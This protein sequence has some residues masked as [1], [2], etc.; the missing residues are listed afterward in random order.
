MKLSNYY[1]KHLMGQLGPKNKSEV[2]K[3]NRSNLLAPSIDYKE[4]LKFADACSTIEKD[5][6]YVVRTALKSLPAGHG[7]LG[8]L[9]QSCETLGA[10]C[11]VGYRFQ[12]LSRSGMH[13]QLDYHENKVSS[14]VSMDGHDP[15]EVGVLVEYFQGSLIAIASYLVESDEPIQ[16]LAI[17]FMHQPRAPIASYQRLFNC[18]NI[19]FSQP[20]NKI[21]FNRKIMDCPIERADLGAKHVLLQEAKTQLTS[22]LGRKLQSERIKALL[23]E[24]SPFNRLSIAECAEKLQLKESSLKR[25]LQNEGTNYKTIMNSVLENLAKQ[26]LANEEYS[27]QYISQQL[28]FSDRSAFARSFKRW[29]GESPLEYR[30]NYS[31]LQLL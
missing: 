24:Q 15:E 22:L 2:K 30:K 12:H 29:S 1:Y 9:V 27:I 11:A 31:S 23:L 28:G 10:A 3:P 16:P 8:L 14:T 18:E 6:L 5:P 26:Y 7:I 21:T 13:S 25:H 4:L 20:C 19:S 17:Q